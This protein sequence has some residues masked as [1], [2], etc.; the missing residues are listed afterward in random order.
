MNRNQFIS[1]MDNPDKLS[2]S[3]GIL[4]AELLKS[5]PYFQTAHLLYAKSLHN[6][7]SVHYNTQLKTTATYAT[8]RK[9]L[10]YLITNKS[11]AKIEIVDAPESHKIAE[12]N[13]NVKIEQLVKE[14]VEQPIATEVVQTTTETTAIE[15]IETEVQITAEIETHEI[16]EENKNIKVEQLIEKEA[17]Q[18]IA[19]EIVKTT[20]EIATSKII[21]AEVQIT[22]E[23]VT[24][25]ITVIEQ[26]IIDE[27]I[28]FTEQIKE[29][30]VEQQV[31]IENVTGTTK[32]FKADA[33]EKID[34]STLIT[35][36]KEEII[37]NNT[38]EN[39]EEVIIDELEK[40]FLA[41]AAIS[42]IELEVSNTE[43]LTENEKLVEF[44]DEQVPVRVNFVLNTPIEPSIVTTI[45]IPEIENAETEVSISHTENFDSSQAHSFTD[46]LKHASNANEPAIVENKLD[47]SSSK[48][49]AA[50]L[51][52]KFLRE[53][54]RMSKPKTE[55][56]NPVNMAKQSV[57]EDITFV[58]E[59]LAKI[60]VLQGNY[61]KALK[62][63]ENL[64][65]KYP[66]KR[67]YFAAQIKNLRKLI[68]QQKQ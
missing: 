63:Y 5:F 2:G 65:L 67:L 21:E 7:H 13:K 55:F 49:A 61:I 18:Y 15:I 10:H 45:E 9:V 60:F 37:T 19:V 34:A 53:E 48:K 57:A 12:E 28:E 58:S 32:E 38:I 3:D 36:S 52:D 66:E 35:T 8:D 4:L 6:E 40:E 62:A 64:R 1:F 59:T 42:V 46:W 24:S 41:Q 51:I 68:N 33:I 25:E 56:Y 39:T 14:E 23:T 44:K 43:L 16:A 54:P 26:A 47:E 30:V 22:E 29:I 50:D 27:N 20:S 31:I 17:E 11:E